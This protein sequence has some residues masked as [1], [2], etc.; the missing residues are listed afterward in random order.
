MFVGEVVPGFPASHAL[1]RAWGVLGEGAALAL[2]QFADPTTADDRNMFG[3]TGEMYIPGGA[4]RSGGALTL[5]GRGRQRGLLVLSSG[6]VV[7]Q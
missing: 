5:T 2:T 3:R 1:L 7:H 4:G 6:G